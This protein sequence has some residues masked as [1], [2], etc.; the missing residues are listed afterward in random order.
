MATSTTSSVAP[1]HRAAV[2]GHPI[3]HSLS[4]VL[5]AAA[6]HDLGLDR[7]GWQ[8]T[9]VDVTSAALADFIDSLDAEWAGLSLT[10]PLKES[11]IPLLDEVEPDAAAVRAVNTV[12]FD[13]A[14]RR[15]YNTDIT[16]LVG[17]V[18]DAGVTAGT[19]TVLGAGATARSA[20][21]ALARCGVREVVAVARR[22]E[23][24]QEIV[25]LAATFDM[26]AVVGG[27]P[28]TDRELSSDVVINTVP[29]DVVSNLAPP[30]APGLLVDVLYDPWPTPLAAVWDEAGGR[31]VGGLD[32]LVRQAVEQVAL[33]TGRRPDMDAM[34]HAGLA[35]LDARAGA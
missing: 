21:A 13:G 12:V 6:Y 24:A 20:V 26:S 18:S 4:P 3:A 16:G 17:I 33:M 22:R 9:A 23:A 27:W 8:Y 2:L 29:A 30:A 11:A 1:T 10:M 35:A 31:V 5:H 15:G 32:L 19:A 25:D 14:K 7:L 28:A 34:R